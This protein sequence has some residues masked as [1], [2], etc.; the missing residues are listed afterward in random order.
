MK[1][2]NPVIKKY[3]EIIGNAI[4]I[5][6]YQRKYQWTPDLARQLFIDLKDKF[7]VLNGTS[8]EAKDYLNYLIP[9]Y[10]GKMFYLGQIVKT[11]I[12]GASQIV[13]G[14]QRLTTLFLIFKA[15]SDYSIDEDLGPSDPF[16]EIFSTY[17]SPKLEPSKEDEEVVEFILSRKSQKE[18]QKNKTAE[19]KEMNKKPHVKNFKAI[20]NE[21][22]AWKPNYNQLINLMQ[23]IRDEVKFLVVE[24]NDIE[25]AINFFEIMNSKSIALSPSDLIK[26]YVLK[27]A[28]DPELAAK[29][30]NDMIETLGEN[31]DNLSK[32]IRFVYIAR[33]GSTSNKKLFQNVKKLPKEHDS[34]IPDLKKYL[35]PYR[36]FMGYRDGGNR[37]VDSLTN[38]IARIG[39]RESLTPIILEIIRINEDK[40]KIDLLEDLVGFSY[41]YFFNFGFKANAYAPKV[42]EICKNIAAGNT[43]NVLKPLFDVMKEQIAEGESLTDKTKYTVDDFKFSDDDKTKAIK[44]AK[45]IFPIMYTKEWRKIDNNE[46]NVEFKL[47]QWDIEHIYPK[48]PAADS[49]WVEI[50][51]NTIWNIGNLIPI[52]DKKNRTAKNDEFRIKYLYYKGKKDA[53]GNDVDGLKESLLFKEFFD[54]FVPEELNE[55]SSWDEKAIEDRTKTLF[56]AIEEKDVLFLKKVNNRYK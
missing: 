28:G 21:I 25:D 8:K 27:S 56:K 13:D 33:I 46:M 50:S 43:D 16:Y 24:I 53:K 29:S 18:V 47:Y 31:S 39:A 36:E 23:F 26:N 12:D 3:K 1:I 55:N 48:T 4:S 9:S 41:K 54:K 30:W 40:R 2:F 20:Y 11:N 42:T 19:V 38:A 32:F 22:K 17:L 49:S 37:E 44:I 7:E 14:Q 5:P 51:E 52:S 10:E 45:A 35:E 34:F 15:I 6:N